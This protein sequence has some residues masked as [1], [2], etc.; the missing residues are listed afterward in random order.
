MKKQQTVGERANKLWQRL[1]PLPGGKWLFSK[2]IGFAI[3]YTGSIQ[4]RVVSLQ[5]GHAIVNLHDRRRVRNH[6]KSIHAIALAN[7]AEFTTG[8][9]TL[10]GMPQ[11]SRAI[12]TGLQVEYHKKARGTLKSE[13]HS[14]PPADAVEQSVVVEAK[15][16]DAW[17]DCVATGLATWLIGPERVN[18]KNANSEQ[19]SSATTRQGKPTAAKRIR[20]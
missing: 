14:T 12:L 3:P 8:I 2:L 13:S 19:D 9:A 6:L 18:A 11:G 15:I 7:L 5:P 1:S 16:Y 20:S 17:G 10:S 4:P